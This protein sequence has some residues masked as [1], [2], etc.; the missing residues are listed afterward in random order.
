MPVVLLCET[1]SN[2]ADGDKAHHFLPLTTNRKCSARSSG[3][4]RRHYRNE[5]RIIKA[6]SGAEALDG[7]SFFSAATRWRCSWP[8]SVCRA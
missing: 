2:R 1:Q 6:G 7:A 8:I 4:L 3:D 5:Y